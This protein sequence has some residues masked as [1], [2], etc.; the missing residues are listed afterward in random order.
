MSRSEPCRC[1]SDEIGPSAT[2]Q[3]FMVKSGPSRA[4][5]AA[6]VKSLA[7]EAELEV[8][9]LIQGIDRLAIQRDDGDAPVRTG[10]GRIAEDCADGPGE[11]RRL[12]L[13]G[14]LLDWAGRR[15]RG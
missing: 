4:S 15:R 11:V 8:L 6:V 9:L 1:P 2:T 12:W 13:A 5:A 3:V 7:F 14:G 10:H